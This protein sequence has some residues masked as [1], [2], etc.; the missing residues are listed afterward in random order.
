MKAILVFTCFLALACAGC[1][2]DDSSSTGTG[3]APG[4]GGSGNAPGGSADCQR[5]CE[6]P[7]I[8]D[9]IDPGEVSEC[10][11]ACEMDGNPLADCAAET[12]AV[13]DCIED[14]NCAETADCLPQFTAF[15]QCFSGFGF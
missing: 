4:T 7:C 9:V 12:V 13:L 6:S 10:V 5:I 2:S 1:G 8:S 3:A 14:F 11:T 15:A